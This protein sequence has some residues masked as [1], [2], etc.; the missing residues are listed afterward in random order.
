MQA[1]KKNQKN[2]KIPNNNKSPKTAAV[3][4]LYIYNHITE[5]LVPL[6]FLI[7]VPDVSLIWCLLEYAQKKNTCALFQLENPSFDRNL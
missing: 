2:Q 1:D 5:F 4:Y 6:S 7:R 3:L